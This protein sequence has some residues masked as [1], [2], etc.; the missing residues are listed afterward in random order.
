M[1]VRKPRPQ[2]PRLFDLQ[3]VLSN[4]C[5]VSSLKW[6]FQKFL[7]G[8]FEQLLR[9]FCV[10]KPFGFERYRCWHTLLPFPDPALFKILAAS[11]K[12]AIHTGCIKIGITKKNSLSLS[13]VKVDDQIRGISINLFPGWRC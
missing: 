1:F 8:V 11:A 2:M 5:V 7:R 12:F 13:A 6:I 9:A 4:G 10:K 3:K